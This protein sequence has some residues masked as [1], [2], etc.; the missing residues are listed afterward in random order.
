MT[1]LDYFV[2]IVVVASVASGATRGILKGIISV[3]SSL[4]GL[5]L[6]AQFYAYAA[7]PF[8]AMKA[9]AQWSSLLGFVTV[10]VAVLAAGSL[11][12]LWLRSRLKRAR[13][14][15]VD[16]LMGAGFGLLRGWLICSAI[17]LALTAFPVR[18]VAVE[19]AVFAP[20]LIEGTHVVA[21]LTSEDMRQRFLSG[22]QTVKK[23]W[24]QQ[25]AG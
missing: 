13:L 22:Y 18:P 9:T 16:H 3:A 15:W 8:A 4:A 14:T 6:A 12:T 7:I 11:L 21:Y 1:V 20:V 5:V 2:L 24:G 10:F 25:E 17:Y 23:L 19:R